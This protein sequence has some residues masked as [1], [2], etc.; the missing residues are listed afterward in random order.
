MYTLLIITVNKWQQDINILLLCLFQFLPIPDIPISGSRPVAYGTVVLEPKVSLFGS[1]TGISHG[2]FKYPQ[3]LEYLK[4]YS[5][6]M[7]YETLLPD[8]YEGHGNLTAEG[9]HDRTIVYVG[10]VKDCFITWLWIYSI[11][12]TDYCIFINL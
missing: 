4:Q 12:K 6:F 1:D 2:L 3:T 8:G 7:W 10:K 9:I 5:G 11:I